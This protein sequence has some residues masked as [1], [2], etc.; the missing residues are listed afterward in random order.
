VSVSL[1]TGNGDFAP[2]VYYATTTHFLSVAIGD[3]NGDGK[4]DI[5]VTALAVPENPGSFPEGVGFPVGVMLNQGDG[6]FAPVVYTTVV[7]AGTPGMP[8]ATGS[9]ATVALGDLNGDGKLDLAV[10]SVA[11]LPSGVLSPTS[12]WTE[13]LSLSVLLNTGNGT[14]AAPV[15]QTVSTAT[16]PGYA[17]VAYVG[18]T[19]QDL[20]GD[21]A[22]DLAVTSHVSGTVAVLLNTGTGAGTFA[23]PVVYSVAGADQVAVADLNGDKL[24]DLAVA[25]NEP[26]VLL[27]VGKGAFAAPVG[28]T[29]V[30]SPGNAS[31]VA[32]GD[33]NGDGKPDLA[34]VSGDTAMSVLINTGNGTFGAAVG[35]PVVVGSS[36]IVAADLNGDGKLDLAVSPGGYTSVLINTGNGTFPPAPPVYSVGKDPMSVAVGDLDGD[37]IPDLAVATYMGGTGVSV[38][39][40]A[41]D[42]TF[43]AAG[44]YFFEDTEVVEMADL[45]GDGELDLAVLGNNS[46]SV[47]L[48]KGNGTF[49]AGI[50]YAWGPTNDSHT[51]MAVGDLNGDG[52]PDLAVTGSAP[53]VG[54]GFVSVLINTGNG[55]FAP[56]VDYTVGE[57]PTGVAIGDLSGEGRGDLAV[58][59]PDQGTVSVLLNTGGGV[60]GAPV[61]YAM[62]EAVEPTFIQAIDLNGD[63]KPDLVIGNGG[64]VTVMI[65]AGGGTFAPAVTY[66]VSATWLAVG[67]LNGDGVPDIAGVSANIMS[68]L[69][70]QGDGTF[71]PALN[72]VTGT[73]PNANGIAVGDLNGDGRT[74]LVVTNQGSNTVS[75]LLNVCLP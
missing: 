28:Y 2:P 52:L 30:E 69:L 55:T 6:T 24:P 12:P 58:V 48:N 40:N 62:M 1:G 63:Q 43:T 72:Y 49:G 38:L 34:F 36:S 75:V 27:N 41:G 7:F 54:D 33:L 39:H 45:D 35:Y 23:A 20:N 25:G 71:A 17:P 51:A 10:V 3:V 73:D 5:V 32:A 21:G 8:A 44:T 70:N 4:P 60:F 66:P 53:G 61:D 47:F 9:A 14:F 56:A 37:K 74:D 59:N 16:G 13:T 11:T 67:D 31:G 64:F 50:P 29:G 26:T 18:V 46:V 57:S 19:A 65:N 22:L 68:V 42:G 15:N